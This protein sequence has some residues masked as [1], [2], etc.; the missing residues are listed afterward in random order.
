MT[1]H[2]RLIKST[3]PFVEDLL[4]SYG[5]FFPLASA[6]TTNDSIVQVGTYG[7][8]DKPLSDNLISNL[9][10]AMRAKMNEYQTIAIFYDVRVVE[11]NTELKTDAV[12]IFTESKTEGSAFTFYYPY[13]LAEDNKLTFSTYTWKDTNK[14]EIFIG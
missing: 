1:D 2:E 6:I 4:K 14:K 8:D 13:V 11:P 9:K 10:I 3:L 12:A 5:E 7:C